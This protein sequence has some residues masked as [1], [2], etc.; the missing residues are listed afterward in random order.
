MECYDMNPSSFEG[1]LKIA[2]PVWLINGKRT[3]LMNSYRGWPHSQRRIPLRGLEKKR[4][5]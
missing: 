2:M 1:Y 5:F 4:G 3:I